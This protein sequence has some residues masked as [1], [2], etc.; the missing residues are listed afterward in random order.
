MRRLLLTALL[1]ALAPAAASAQTTRAFELCFQS[2]TGSC[3]RFELTTSEALIGGVRYGTLFDLLLTHDEGT[4]PGAAVASALLA[5]SFHYAGAAA[6]PVGDTD[7]DYDPGAPVLEPA[8]VGG[9]PDPAQSDGWALQAFGSTTDAAGNVLSLANALLL[10]PFPAP[11]RA[12]TQG[13]G[14]CGVAGAAGVIDDARRTDLWTCGGGAYRL[15]GFT[16]TWFDVARV[17]AVGVQTLARF[18]GAPIATD[19]FCTATLDAPGS[20]GTD[21]TVDAFGLPTFGDVCRARELSVGPPPPTVVPEPSSLALLAGGLGLLA[22]GA[23]RR[24]DG[25]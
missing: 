9:A 2:G 16:A 24:R 13:I 15:T 6:A 1:A 12:L 4:D 25:A 10:D 5:V 14:G 21:G 3:S 8:G 18:A 20:V 22:V 7:T 11:G 19:P 23:R 17:N